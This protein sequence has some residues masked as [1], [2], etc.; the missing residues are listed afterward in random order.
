MGDDDAACADHA[1]HLV[2][3]ALGCA[4]EE[5]NTEND[6]RCKRDR[7]DQEENDGSVADW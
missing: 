6:E 1:P 2:R 4:V 7:K 3:E 5:A